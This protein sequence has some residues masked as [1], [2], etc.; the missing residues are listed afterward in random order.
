MKNWKLIVAVL[1]LVLVASL[2]FVVYNATRETPKTQD[3]N[4][5]APTEQTPATAPDGTTEAPQPT[6]AA[7]GKNITVTV[8]YQDGSSKDFTYQTDAE[9]LGTVLTESGL[10][11]GEQ[12]AYGL[13]IKVV[14][15]QRAVYELDQAYWQ[16]FVGEEAA[17][18]G[19]DQI[20]IQDGASYR[21]VYTNA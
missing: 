8:V 12:G 17:M 4:T 7:N 19:A 6:D 10:V 16:V 15:G 21:L 1:A 20:V 5:P 2:M 3:N 14:D 11:E 13:Y 9:Y 18:T